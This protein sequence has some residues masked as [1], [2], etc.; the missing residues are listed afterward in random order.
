MQT[1]PKKVVNAWAMY[2]WAN[3]VYNLVITSTIFPAYYENVTKINGDDTVIF[4][5]RS[6]V[7]TALYN[8]AIAFAI[9][10]VAILIPVLSSI[11]DYKGNKKNFMRFFCT[12]GS[13]ACTCLFFFT[14]KGSIAIGITCVIHLPALAFGAALYFI[15]LTCPR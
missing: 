10:V 15:I 7:N 1:A 4:L 14:G 12:A 13:I 6:F 2:D 5:G 8:Y 9:L 11:A 3:S